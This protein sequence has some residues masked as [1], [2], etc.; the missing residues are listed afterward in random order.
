MASQE[1]FVTGMSC[2]M[3]IHSTQRSFAAAENTASSSTRVGKRRAQHELHIKV[4]KKQKLDV[5]ATTS[6]SELKPTKGPHDRHT[7][8]PRLTG[9]PV[10]PLF[11]PASV[12]KNSFRFVRRKGNTTVLHG[13]HLTPVLQPKIAAFDLDGTLIKTRTGNIFPNGAADWK[14][15]NDAVPTRLKEVHDQE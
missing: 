4:T 11:E 12:R 6:A 13:I 7:A 5:K 3:D 1:T 9:R 8:F 14:W 15:W 2:N 10:F